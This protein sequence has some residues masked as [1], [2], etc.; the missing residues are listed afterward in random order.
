M[1]P[2]KELEKIAQIAEDP[3]SVL[4]DHIQETE[5]KFG[6]MDDRLEHLKEIDDDLEDLDERLKEESKKNLVLNLEMAKEELSDVSSKIEEQTKLISEQHRDKSKHSEICKYLETIKELLK[7]EN[8]EDYSDIIKAIN[9]VSDKIKDPKETKIDLNPVLDQL[10]SFKK[11]IRDDRVKVELLDKQIDRIVNAVSFTGGK[12]S[13]GTFN[14]LGNQINPATE[15]KQNDILVSL[16]SISNSVDIYAVQLAVDSG[17]S[18]ITYI[19]KAVAGSTSSSAVWRINRMTDTSGDL[20][21]QFADGDSNFDNVWDN[22][23][24][25][26]Y[27]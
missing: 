21:I 10:K 8:K 14:K 7:K 13:S 2:E 9:K 17:D 1:T 26:S 4:F 16:N 20:S 5:S 22:R 11:V 12:G 6:E 15:E 3:E 27:S 18:T 24:S 23:E 25:L 19:G